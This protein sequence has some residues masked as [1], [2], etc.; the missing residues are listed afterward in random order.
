MRDPQSPGAAL[1][2]LVTGSRGFIGRRVVASPQARAEEIV[3]WKADVRALARCEEA[4]DAVLHLAAVSRYDRFNAV[5]HESYATNV[6]GTAA[7][8]NYCGRV[9]A[10]C[11]LA[12]SSAVYRSPEGVRPIGED[13]AI[14]PTSAY[15]ISKWLAE[16][17]CH[18]QACD[19][20]VASTVLRLFNVYGPGQ[21]PAFLVSY[22]VGCLRER[23]PIFLRMPDG[24]RDF[25]Y[26][27]DVVDALFRAARL[28][29]SGV[30]V[31]NIG[32][33]QA[34]RVLDM[35]RAAERVFGPAVAVEKGA[36][37][38]EEIAA[39]VADTSRARAELGWTPRYDLESGLIAMRN[40]WHA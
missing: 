21:H 16:S 35:V 3:E 39:V 8:L 28:R 20:G 36:A 33:G 4:V 27:T 38:P 10:R 14:G 26:V 2:I 23:R 11:V 1:R 17:L 9:R 19:A 6:V 22:V 37:H 7:V 18:Q 31:L 13:A 32:S 5:P 34:V 15:G 25:V 12:S 30:T 40:A 29:H 24:L